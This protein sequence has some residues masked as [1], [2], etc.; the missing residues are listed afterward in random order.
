MSVSLLS[1]GTDLYVAFLPLSRFSTS[2]EAKSAA[3]SVQSF[4]LK[5]RRAFERQP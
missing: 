5:N 1:F 2:K 3:S 4:Y